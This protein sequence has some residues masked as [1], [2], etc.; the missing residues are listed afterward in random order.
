MHNNSDNAG[1]N[2]I[3][4]IA[5]SSEAVIISHG[6]ESNKLRTLASDA[7]VE[8]SSVKIDQS[9]KLSDNFDKKLKNW[10]SNLKRQWKEVEKE[11]EI[12]GL[13]ERIK[14]L[15]GEQST[16]K[17]RESTISY[18]TDQLSNGEFLQNVQNQANL[19][20]SD[21][22]RRKTSLKQH[23]MSSET[24]ISLDKKEESC[25]PTES[26]S[27]REEGSSLN[28]P[29][30]DH[31]KSGPN[32]PVPPSIS[33]EELN[34][35]SPMRSTKEGSKE[36]M[37]LDRFLTQNIEKHSILAAFCDCWPIVNVEEVSL[38]KQ[39]MFKDFVVHFETREGY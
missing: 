22:E 36:N 17:S 13:I 26:I 9:G 24:K 7:M 33:R 10:S 25:I 15:F 31:V 35:S 4:S 23:H 18:V 11:L 19:Q 8:D 1:L 3:Q 16:I 38:T 21:V 39:S 37:V 29:N 28:L 6:N 14:G 30:S 34:S 5:Q 2:D 32:Y 20:K 12:Q 27:E